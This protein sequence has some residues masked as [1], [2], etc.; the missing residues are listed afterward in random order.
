MELFPFLSQLRAAS[1]FFELSS[2]RPDSVLVAIAVPGERWEVEFCVDGG[3]EVE[4]FSSGGE[5]AG[6]EKLAELF[7]RHTG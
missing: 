4:V 7:E 2:V 1:I 3:V 5:I 6:S